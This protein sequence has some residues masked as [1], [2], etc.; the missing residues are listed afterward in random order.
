MQIQQYRWQKILSIISAILLILFIIASGLYLLSNKIKPKTEL[1]SSIPPTI[2]PAV[3]VGYPLVS[4]QKCNLQIRYPTGWN[5]NVDPPST[6]G[7]PTYDIVDY[8]RKCVVFTDSADPSITDRSGNTRENIY[9]VVQETP[10]GTK[11][12]SI[13]INDLSSYISATE[14]VT[15]SKITNIADINLGGYNGKYFEV[16]AWKLPAIFIFK[17]DE[18]IYSMSWNKEYS[19]ERKT[20]LFF[21]FLSIILANSPI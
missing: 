7:N 13:S 14:K 1:K 10:E 6:E 15:G 12:S 3:E 19:G 4:S 9:I 21:P 17:K 5:T 18:K 2:Q 8:N 11:V 16:N 20:D